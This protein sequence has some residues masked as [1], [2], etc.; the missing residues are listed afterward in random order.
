M[1]LLEEFGEKYQWFLQV[2]IPSS[3]TPF[4]K[5]HQARPAGPSA[6]AS[7]TAAALAYKLFGTDVLAGY[8]PAFAEDLQ[9]WNSNHPIF[10]KLVS[11]HKIK[12]IFDVGV[13][14][15][16]ST[17]AL[18][19]LLREF[20]IDGAVVAV[21]TFFGSTEH[22][23]RFRKDRI[24]DS[25]LLGYGY[26]QLYWQFVSNLKHRGCDAYVVP[27]PQTTENAIRILKMHGISA[28]L[29]HLD[30]AH[31]YE[32]VL[33]DAL[34]FWD[35][36]NPGGFLI[37]DDY[38]PSWPGVIRAANDFSNETGVEVTIEEPKWVA[39]KPVST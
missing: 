24:F 29:I 5:N 35:L 16:G 31:E 10:R 4:H 1:S 9:G 18:S 12:V 14:K 28:D 15:G 39:Q 27:L 17:I 37:G 8:Q 2:H 22:W 30:A 34:G 36:L 6:T 13:W 20:D 32:S 11:S 33:R 21:D 7:R 25:L 3:K 19:N 23:N 26:S 38:H